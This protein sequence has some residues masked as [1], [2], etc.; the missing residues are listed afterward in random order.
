MDPAELAMYAALM[1]S[2]TNVEMVEYLMAGWVCWQLR[3][4]LDCWQLPTWQQ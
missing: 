2:N 3:A 4:A 1:T